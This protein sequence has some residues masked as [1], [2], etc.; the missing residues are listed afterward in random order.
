MLDL[1][2]GASAGEQAH[3]GAGSQEASAI[4]KAVPPVLSIVRR[5]ASPVV[6]YAAT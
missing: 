3:V 4:G 5:T 6:S 2:S 1:T